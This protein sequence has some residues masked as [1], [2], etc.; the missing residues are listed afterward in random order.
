MCSLLQASEGGVGL[1]ECA[2][3]LTLS[4]HFRWLHIWEKLAA[5]EHSEGLEPVGQQQDRGWSD[6]GTLCCSC[7]C[8]P[9]VLWLLS[10][11]TSGGTAVPVCAVPE[12]PPLSGAPCQC[13]HAACQLVANY[14]GWEAVQ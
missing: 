13:V 3:V 4:S 12:T 6:V 5:S 2:R 9:S 11:Q 8:A 1:S 10:L 14:G 7:R